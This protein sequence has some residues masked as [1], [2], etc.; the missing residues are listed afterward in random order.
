MAEVPSESRPTRAGARGVVG[1]V[2][3]AAAAT[4]GTLVTL[5]PGG[6]G[7]GVTCDE[8]YHVDNGKRL[9]TA[10]RHQDL[11]FFTPRNIERNFPW[12]P[13]GPPVH[14]PLG[15]WILGWT[16]HLFDS[17]PEEPAALVI[18]AARFGPAVALGLLVLLVGLVTARMEGPVA[19]SVG[20]AAVVLVPRVFAHGHFAA[21]DTITALLFVAAVLAIIEA[22]ACGGRPRHFAAAGVVWGL[23][24]LTRLHGLLV[25]PPVVIWLA[26]RLGRR[27]VVPVA[28]WLAAGMVVFFAGWPWLWLAPIARLKQFLVTATDRQAVHV[29]YAGQVWADCDVPWHYPVVMFVAVLPLGLLLL[30]LLGIWAGRRRAGGEPGYLWL[31]LATVGFVLLVFAWPGTPVYDGVRLF[32]MVFPLW[33]ISV[34]VGGKWVVEHPLWRSVSLRVRLG[35]LAMLLAMQGVG[36]IVYHPC[37]LSHYSLVVGG[38]AGAERLGFEVTYWG[39]AV[40]ESLLAEAAR[41]ARGDQ[42]VFGPDLA[43]FQIPGVVISSPAMW[44]KAQAEGRVPLIGWD[45]SWQQPPAGCRYGVF[46][47]R[48]ADLAQVPEELL[49]G[50]DVAAYQKQG[51]WLARLVEFS[52]G[53]GREP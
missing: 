4:V 11:A 46:Y 29:F 51:V 20:A 13:G 30:G 31:V 9:V 27:A 19:G 3:I 50:S 48:K 2:L 42:V 21:L 6:C 33:A 45:E 10:L 23:A 25:L 26:W 38:L 49:V 28:V 43:P 39:D 5:G 44:Q 34:G 35:T 52:E 1:P 14:P 18:M 53:G 17:R 7:P 24:L 15:N 41:R 36:L 37:Q 32:L 22:D 40:Q 12:A 16:H 8:A 47:N